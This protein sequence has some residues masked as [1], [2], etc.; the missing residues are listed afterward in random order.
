V[1][2]EII[3]A[4]GLNQAHQSGG[5][6]FSQIIQIFMTSKKRCREGQLATSP[7][8]SVVIK[9]HSLGQAKDS[10]QHASSAVALVASVAR[11]R[12]LREDFSSIF[13]SSANQSFIKRVPAL[14]SSRALALRSG[15]Y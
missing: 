6:Y 8:R 1:I 15:R 12:L 10:T 3:A 9:F 5:K 2:F 11:D 7:D 14:S 13:S 4:C